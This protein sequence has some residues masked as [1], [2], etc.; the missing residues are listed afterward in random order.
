L[1]YE[2]D[3]MAP[4][5][6]YITANVNLWPQMFA[7]IGNPARLA[8]L[9]GEQRDWLTGAVRETS[10]ASVDL[11]KADVAVADLCRDGA[12]FAKASDAQIDALR[13]AFA[14]VY[15]ELERDSVT[16]RFIDQIRQLAAS[17]SPAVAVAVPDGCSGPAPGVAVQ[18][19]V[20]PSKTTS[21]T[22]LDG[23]WETSY[24]LDELAATKLVDPSEVTPDNA[25]TFMIMFDRGVLTDPT[26]PADPSQPATTYVVDGDT[27]TIYAPDAS[28]GG[29]VPPPGPAVW[30]YRW[31]IYNDTLT[32][33]KLWGE[34]PDCSLSVSGG[35]CEPSMYIVKP[36][37]RIG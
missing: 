18:P 27:L 13:S 12:R 32:F 33:E 15:A 22:P 7:V 5:A 10:A 35:M 19:S 23:T 34:E 2:R 3:N 4:R 14:S 30:T 29:H 21:V 24:T 16:G 26:K 37:H 8:A 28:G 11:V 9:P 25:G 1:G 17:S 31:S 20:P 6:P 36:W